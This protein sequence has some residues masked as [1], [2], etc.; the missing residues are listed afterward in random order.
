MRVPFLVPILFAGLSSYAQFNFPFPTQN[1]VWTQW[2]DHWSTGDWPPT[3]Y[4]R[5]YYSYYMVG[6]DT[7]INGSG[8]AQVF[9]YIGNYTAAIRDE[10]GR[11]LVV[12]HGL[13]EE[14]LLYDFT[15][16]AGVDTTLSVW[17]LWNME[18][19]E[20]QMRGEGPI[21]EDG[22]IVIQGEGYQWIE[23]IGCTAGLFMEPWINV[24]G[25]GLGLHC[26][27]VENVKY[28]PTTSAGSCEITNAVSDRSSHQLRVFPNPA[29]DL[30][31]I[32]YDG[33]WSG[34]ARISMFDMLGEEVHAE[35]VGHGINGWQLDMRALTS[36]VYTIR[37]EV[38]Q[39]ILS[40][41]VM[42]HR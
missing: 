24:S 36:G 6:T 7:L 39:E 35:V 19:V 20:V 38:G 9:D 31:V 37:F 42:V 15:I 10:E 3:Y 25:Y 2:V 23:G 13:S 16:P 17:L 40:H 22:R 30:M 41:R 11:V 28:Y 29:R 5:D 21:G 18:Q 26:M 33:N 8:Y 27:S 32:Q 14:F 1:A 12:P 4:G 34:T